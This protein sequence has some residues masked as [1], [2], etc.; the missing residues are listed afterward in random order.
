[1]MYSKNIPLSCSYCKYG[2][3][4]SNEM[5]CVCSKYGLVFITDKCSK[6]KYDPIKRK[7]SPPI[8]IDGDDNVEIETL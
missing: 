1:M 6:F 5:H 8:I 7:P 2:K 4:L 3:I